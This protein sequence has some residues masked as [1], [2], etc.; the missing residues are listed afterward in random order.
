MTAATVVHCASLAGL[1]LC[2]I[3][4]FILLVIAPLTGTDHAAVDGHVAPLLANTDIWSK[5]YD[6]I[7]TLASFKAVRDPSLSATADRGRRIPAGP[8]E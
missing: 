4:C 8:L 7:P 1:V 5:V 2:F 3:A 6:F